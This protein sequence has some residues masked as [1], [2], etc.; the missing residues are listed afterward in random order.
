[1]KKNAVNKHN[2][3]PLLCG[4]LFLLLFIVWTLLLKVIDV[5]PIGADST[6]VG[7]ATFNNWF[8]NLTNVNMTLYIITD[9]SGL[10]PVFVCFMFAVIG[11]AQLV[12]RKSLLKVDYD[13]IILGIYYISVIS[14]YL[15]F[16]LVTINYRPILING[17]LEKSYPSSTTLLVLSVMPTLSFQVEIKLKN[18]KIKKILHFTV[19]IFSLF[20]VIGRLLS[21]VHWITDIIG[22][23]LLSTGLFNT[24]MGTVLLY[25]NRRSEQ[26]GFPRKT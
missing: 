23:I 1:M 2:I 6:A 10:V 21:G 4:L 8:H 13:I 12:M 19:M 9:W 11:F 5:Q 25:K 18:N 20:M 14:F 3:V 22:G 7:F 26:Y 24:Y 16:E 17:L 15:I